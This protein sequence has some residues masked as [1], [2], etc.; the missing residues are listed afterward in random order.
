M[1][2]DETTDTSPHHYRLTQTHHLDGHTI[3]IRVHRDF[4]AHQSW[5]AAEVLTPALTW[6]ELTTAPASDWHPATPTTAT[7]SR[8][9]RPT[10]WPACGGSP[11]TSPSGPSGCCPPSPARTLPRPPA[12][13]PAAPATEPHPA[14]TSSATTLPQHQPPSAQAANDPGFWQPPT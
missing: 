4:Y 2:I 5:A 8:T 3:R 11:M 10:A 12:R 9:R 14:A 7:A 6:T 13:T 1:L